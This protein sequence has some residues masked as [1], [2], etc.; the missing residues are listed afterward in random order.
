MQEDTLVALLGFIFVLFYLVVIAVMLV[1]NW[2]I[3][4]KA[5]EPGWTSLIPFYNIIILLQMTGKPLWWIALMIIPFVNIIASPIINLLI[6]I[7]LSKKFGKGIGFG[8]GLAFLP[9]I[10]L[11]ILAFGPAKYQKDDTSSNE[12]HL[13]VS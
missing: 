10:F 12:D 3:H 8:I 6:Y 2:K 4:E 9:I 7:E 11:P 1:S 13:I 5:G